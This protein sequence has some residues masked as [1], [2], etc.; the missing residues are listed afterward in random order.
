MR[1]KQLSGPVLFEWAAHYVM[2]AFNCHVIRLDW[3]RDIQTTGTVL[4]PGV[5]VRTF[6]EEVGMVSRTEEESTFN[7]DRYFLIS[8]D[9]DSRGKVFSL[10]LLNLGHSSCLEPQKFRLS[11]LC[12]PRFRLSRLQ[13]QSK[14][15]TVSSLAFESF[16]YGFWQAIGIP[17]SLACSQPSLGLLSLHNDLRKF[18]L[19]NSLCYHSFSLCI[20]Y[21]FCFSGE[22]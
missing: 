12:T 16:E 22:P 9:L 3:I 21:F 18:Y 13:P 4:P 14:N 1:S 11:V 19:V 17:G 15:Y 6:A 8:W 7:V 5:F 10:S 20:S 2:N